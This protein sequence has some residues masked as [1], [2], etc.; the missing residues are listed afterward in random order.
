MK[1]EI[2]EVGKTSKCKVIYK[3]MMESFIYKVFGRNSDL[4]AHPKEADDFEEWLENIM[5]CSL[6]NIGK[7]IGKDFFVDE[8]ADK[9]IFIDDKGCGVSGDDVADGFNLDAY[10]DMGVVA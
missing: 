7:R 2:L 4:D 8:S 3:V 5:C 9:I 6:R 10:L 1:K